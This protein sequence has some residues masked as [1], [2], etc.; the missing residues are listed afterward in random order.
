[1]RLY[2]V[3][4]IPDGRPVSVNVIVSVLLGLKKKA[5][6]SSGEFIVAV[7][8]EVAVPEQAESV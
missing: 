4:V 5:L 8:E 6:V 7:T 3:E 1:V 2:G